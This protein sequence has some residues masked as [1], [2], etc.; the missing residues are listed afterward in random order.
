MDTHLSGLPK[1][2]VPMLSGA[3]STP[4]HVGV[5]AILV[6]FVAN[7]FLPTFKLLPT[8]GRVAFVIS[9]FVLTV[10]YMYNLECVARGGGRGGEKVCTTMAWVGTSLQLL[11]AILAIVAAINYQKHR[12]VV[13]ARQ[14]RRA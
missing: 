6:G 11:N 12:Y 5:L 1:V 8:A 13:D 7:L 3:L 10:F 9:F 14:G 2:H 4:V